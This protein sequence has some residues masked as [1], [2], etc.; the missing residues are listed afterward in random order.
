MDVET[1]DQEAIRPSRFSEMVGQRKL[2]EKLKIAVE[3]ASNRG[4]AMDHALVYGPPGLGKTTLAYVIANELGVEVRVTSGPVLERPADLGGLLTNLGEKDVLFIDEI[5][6][7][8]RVVEEHLYSAMEDYTLDIMIDSG[9]S[10]RSYRISLEKFTLIGATTRLGLLSE[11][12]RSR[13]GMIDRLD[14]YDDKDLCAIV[15]RAAKIL[16]VQ[17][18][19]EGAAEVAGRSRGTPRIAIRLLSRARD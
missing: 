3:A 6:R 5:H 19:S 10:A 15:T 9:P 17:L 2:I 16:N 14:L 13:F 4:E 18:E 11:P 12:M 8:N 7:M 1:S